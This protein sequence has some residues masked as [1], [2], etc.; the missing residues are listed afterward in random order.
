M[1]DNSQNEV[2]S[3]KKEADDLKSR[4]N[5]KLKLKLQIEELSNQKEG[6]ILEIATLKEYII[7][8]RI[9]FVKLNKTMK[10]RWF[11]AMI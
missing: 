4:N 9:K 1:T 3:F 7:V 8:N 10:M 6:F 5:Y 2:F 11:I